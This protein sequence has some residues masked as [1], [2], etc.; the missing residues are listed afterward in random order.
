VLCI[1]AGFDDVLGTADDVRMEDVADSTGSY[2]WPVPYGNFRCTGADPVTGALSRAASATVMSPE[3]VRVVLPLGKTRA[4]AT[5][6]AVPQAAAPA[7]ARIAPPRQLV[8]TGQD[9]MVSCSWLP[10]P[11]W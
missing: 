4:P 2:D 11:W 8:R 9:V 1:W 7:R 10:R 5:P 3:P 6:A